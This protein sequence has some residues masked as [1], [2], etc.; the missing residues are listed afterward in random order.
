MGIARM[1]LQCH[2]EQTVMVASLA[3][4][5]SLGEL[6]GEVCALGKPP[7]L[8]RNRS[9]PKPDLRHGFWETSLEVA[10]YKLLRGRARSPLTTLGMVRVP[11]RS[12]SLTTGSHWPAEVSTSVRTIRESSVRKDPLPRLVEEFLNTSLAPTGGSTPSRLVST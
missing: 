4:S 3:Y 1:D 11:M 10:I 2:A 7:I 5:A 12:I 9:T 8:A 6:A